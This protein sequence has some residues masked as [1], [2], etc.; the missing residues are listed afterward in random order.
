MHYVEIAPETGFRRDFHW[1]YLGLTQV[2]SSVLLVCS[3]QLRALH[4]P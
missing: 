1:K 2:V 3:F 4:I